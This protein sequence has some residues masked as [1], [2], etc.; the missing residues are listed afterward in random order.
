LDEAERIPRGLDAGLDD[1]LPP[2]LAH[3]RTRLRRLPRQ[4]RSRAKVAG[5]LAA[6]ERLFVERGYDSVTADAIAAAAGV[7]TGTF[8]AYFGDKRDAL[9]L[10]LAER[11]DDVLGVPLLDSLSAPA[12]DPGAAVGPLPA[13][14]GPPDRRAAIRAAVARAV[15]R[16]TEPRLV[17]LRRIWF[18]A[19]RRDPELAAYERLAAGYAVAR[20]RRRLEQVAALGHAPLPDVEATAWAIWVLVDALTARLSLLGDA[21]PPAQRMIDAAASLIAAAVLAPPAA[22]RR[23]TSLPVE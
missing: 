16:G 18:V 11:I 19:A 23:V 9:V 6:A 4:Q 14:A 7:S 17:Q 15:E 13:P 8:Y 1:A 2:L 5:L 20:I 21:M 3:V 10:L 22:P 12:P